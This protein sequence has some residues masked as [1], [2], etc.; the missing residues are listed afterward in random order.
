MEMS[1]CIR[2]KALGFTFVKSIETLC[3]AP[4]QREGGKKKGLHSCN[5]TYEQVLHKVIKGRAHDLGL[6]IMKLP[7]MTF[8]VHAVI[9]EMW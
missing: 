2:K 8:D 1:P 5:T 7:G 4:F 3:H 6:F 9:Q